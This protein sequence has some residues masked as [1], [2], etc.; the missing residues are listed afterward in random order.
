VKVHT[1]SPSVAPNDQFEVPESADT[2]ELDYLRLHLKRMTNCFEEYAN[3][4]ED[5]H[6]N[7]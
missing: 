6:E 5:I 4:S 1:S 7:L 3:K 2:T